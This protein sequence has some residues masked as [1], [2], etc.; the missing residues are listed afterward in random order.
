[1][2]VLDGRARIRDIVALADR[3]APSRLSDGVLEAVARTSAAAAEIAERVP[4]YGRSTGVGANRLTAVAA[5]DDEHGMRLLRSHA[6]DA[7]AELPARTVRA[8]LAV[9]LNQLCV[10]GSGIDPRILPALHEMLAT[11]ALPRVRSFGSIGTGD[12][13]ALAGTALTLLGE[14]PATAALE[15][16]PPWGADSAL[17]FISSNALTI[18]R[19]ALVA[20]ELGVL[21]RAARVIA[22]LSCVALAGNRQPFSLTAARAA[23]APGVERVAASLR[24]LLDGAA[25]EPPARIQDPYGLRVLPLTQGALLTAIESVAERAQALLG[26][27]Q[28][29][30]LYDADAGTVTHHGGFFQAALALELD[31][32]NL[33]LARSAP[34]TLSRV[35]MLNDPEYSGARPFLA[36]GPSGASGLMMLEYVAASAIAEIRASALPASVGSVSL[37]RGTEDDAGFASQGAV[38]AERALDGYRVLLGCELVGAARLLRQRGSRGHSGAF[39]EVVTVLTA[40]PDSTLDHDLRADLDA[41]I[42]ALPALAE[43]VPSEA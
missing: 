41:A 12:L 23:A 40:V 3:A 8:M 21:E 6:V 36:E 20:H 43:V 37:S 42:A 32:A 7:G 5:D 31:A 10:P 29:N 16:M 34:T 4:S 30:P 25:P 14:R 22:A 15:P 19:A 33:A 17:A 13:T 11:D 38:Q 28:E 9:R 35:R 27:A 24:A 2:I 26:T 18:G 39:A 1:M